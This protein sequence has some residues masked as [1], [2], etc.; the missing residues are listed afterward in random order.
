MKKTSSQH[1]RCS[2]HTLSKQR[3][4]YFGLVMLAIA[5]GSIFMFTAFPTFTGEHTKSEIQQITG[6]S[7]YSAYIMNAMIRKSAHILIY[8]CLGILFYHVIKKRSIWYAWVLTTI[9]ASLDEWHQSL[10]PG[11]SPLF[12]DVVIDAI[13]AFVFIVVVFFMKN[14]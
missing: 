5:L 11:R 13:A 14:K 3:T 10:V 1:T 12:Q 7:E 6:M 4:R 9:I 8:G 2:K